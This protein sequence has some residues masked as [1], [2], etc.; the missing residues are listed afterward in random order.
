[1][2]EVKEVHF[3]LDWSVQLFVAAGT[4][5][6]VIVALCGDALRARWVRLFM[7]VENARGVYTPTRTPVPS[8]SQPHVIA[9]I[10]QGEARYYHLRV[11]NRSRRFTAHRVDVYLLKV[12][13]VEGGRTSR[14]W[15]GELPMTWEHHDVLGGARE[16]GNAANVDVFSID[17]ERNLI[18]RPLFQP[19]RLKVTYQGPCELI[20]TVQAR[21]DENDSA[22]LR[23]LVNWDG[24]WDADE[25]KMSHH[26]EF[27]DLRSVA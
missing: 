14:I 12:D 2:A 22:E 4:V 23:L 8:A 21:G 17:S 19:L 16:I 15:T 24:A 13:K 10:R 1:V 26:V 20:L 7:F 25:E 5:G 11:A 9:G 6:A 18:L 27:R 3:W